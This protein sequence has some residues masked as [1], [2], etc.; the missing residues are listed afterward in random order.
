MII[1]NGEYMQGARSNSRA[2][3]VSAWRVDFNVSLPSFEPLIAGT[4]N[5]IDLA[6]TSEVPGGPKMAF[7]SSISALLST[8]PPILTLWNFEF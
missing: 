2:H 7:V 8:P 4:R 5:L 1:H 3:V 6:L